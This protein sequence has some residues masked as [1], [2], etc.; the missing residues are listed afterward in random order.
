MA[1]LFL[2][3]TLFIF[4]YQG[5][6]QTLPTGT[7]I[8]I[9]NSECKYYFDGAV[10][11]GSAE[12]DGGCQN[13]LVSGSG[14]LKFYIAENLQYTFVGEMLNGKE[15][16]N[17]LYTY[18]SGTKINGNFN[19]GKIEGIAT[20][21]FKNGDKY[22]GKLKNM[23]MDGEGTYIT[24]GGDKYKGVFK[25]GEISGHFNITHA[26]GTKYVGEVKNAAYHGAGLI[27]LTDGTTIKGTFN[28]Y[29]PTGTIT[30]NYSDA[31]KY[32]GQITNWKPN[33]QGTITY[34]NGDNYTGGW[35]EGAYH[36]KGTYTAKSGFKYTGD[37]VEGK[38]S[39]TGTAIYTNG[40]K[41]TGQWLED[42]MHG[43][44]TLSSMKTQEK[45]IGEYKNGR[46]FKGYGVEV[47]SLGK[48]IFQGDYENSFPVSKTTEIMKVKVLDCDATYE[49]GTY[50]YQPFGRKLMMG[51]GKLTFTSGKYK[52]N[53][54][55]GYFHM[56]KFKKGPFT[57]TSADGTRYVS[58][59]VN[60]DPYAFG[61]YFLDK[62]EKGSIYYSNGN[63]YT[64]EIS[65]LFPSG[66]G[67]MKYSNGMTIS[68]NFSQGNPI[69]GTLILPDGTR[70]NG[71]IRTES[72]G[73]FFIGA[74]Y[75]N[76]SY[77]GMDNIPYN[78]YVFYAN[79]TIRK[80]VNGQ[81]Q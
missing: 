52:G 32:V 9:K 7:W 79:G 65:S 13:N 3:F 5:I 60:D 8:T 24:S 36:G 57:I 56:D 28:N 40:T 1:R 17:G 80:M 29:E 43:Q 77:S 22:E 62:S 12:W 51:K 54:Y 35:K 70:I 33:G 30:I 67:R 41:Y 34:I 71:K 78:G 25:N 48:I 69:K 39:G 23:T 21:I 68:G 58:N 20:V 75:S 31:N 10:T 44:G 63:V 47:D 11:N 72:D 14:T 64:G 42:E 37:F 18:N 81:L 76:D 59:L 38:K 61:L 55:D 4:S 6:A 15:Q 73:T 74:M 49:G 50:F 46:K 53:V 66:E 19:N 16:G 27:T 45:F 26:S 2:F